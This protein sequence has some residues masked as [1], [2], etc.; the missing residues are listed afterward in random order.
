MYR[1][2]HLRRRRNRRELGLFLEGLGDAVLGLAGERIDAPGIGADVI[3]D[4]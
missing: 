4:R 2:T 3:R 1:T